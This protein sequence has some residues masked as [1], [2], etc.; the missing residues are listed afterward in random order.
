[1]K[2]SLILTRICLKHS[3]RKSPLLRESATSQCENKLC[4][5]HSNADNGNNPSH[6]QVPTVTHTPF[7]WLLESI[8]SFL[9]LLFSYGSGNSEKGN[10]LNHT[11]RRPRASNQIRDLCFVCPQTLAHSRCIVVFAWK[12]GA[13][14]Q[15]PLLA[16]PNQLIPSRQGGDTLLNPVPRSSGTKTYVQVNISLGAYHQGQCNN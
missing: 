2:P 4:L 13:Y 5:T 14:W 15:N 12:N 6:A 8:Q 3:K 1:M 9:C 7:L 11:L 16:C 10:N